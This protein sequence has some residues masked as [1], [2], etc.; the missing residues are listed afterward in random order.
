MK[1]LKNLGK[2]LTRAEQKTIIG[3]GIDNCC[4][5]GLGLVIVPGSIDTPGGTQ[6]GTV[7]IEPLGK[8]LKCPITAG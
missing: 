6:M 7:C 4:E 8:R 3:G 5:W 2:V 1:N